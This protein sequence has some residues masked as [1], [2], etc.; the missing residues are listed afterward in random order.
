MYQKIKEKYLAPDKFVF[1]SIQNVI[2]ENN[3]LL[4]EILNNTENEESRELIGKTAYNNRILLDNTGYSEED[5][6]LKLISEQLELDFDNFEEIET[7]EDDQSD[8]SE[9]KAS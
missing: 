5:N 4:L 8:K 1:E 6:N 7:Q 3:E 9:E 2:L